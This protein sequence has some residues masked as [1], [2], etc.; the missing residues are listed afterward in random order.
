MAQIE[1][2][3]SATGA[4][5]VAVD[6]SGSCKILNEVLPQWQWQVYGVCCSTAPGQLF[7][8]LLILIARSLRQTFV[9]D[10]G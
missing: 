9:D 1:Q 7:A 10:V 6:S 3:H 5:S 8:L 4:G 2:L